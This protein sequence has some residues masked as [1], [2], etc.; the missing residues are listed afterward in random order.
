MEPGEII[1]NLARRWYA[2]AR[3]GQALLA[4]AGLGL[5]LAAY[6]GSGPDDFATRGALRL[7]AH[8][9]L[10]ALWAGLGA[11]RAWVR[12][13]AL[14]AGAL[15]LHGAALWVA[16]DRA[17]ARA[18]AAAPELRCSGAGLFLAALPLLVLLLLAGLWALA[19]LA[20][21]LAAALRLD[22]LR[23]PADR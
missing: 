16:A 3:T 13:A 21:L 11:P 5:L 23:V 22:R 1:A 7:V 6:P 15:A 2:R 4:A 10:A 9:A 17:Y 20:R 14:A 18:L 12:S 8:A 19:G